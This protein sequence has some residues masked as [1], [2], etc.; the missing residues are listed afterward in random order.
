M[1]QQLSALE[2]YV[3]D[4]TTLVMESGESPFNVLISQPEVDAQ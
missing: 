3:S 2:G 4:K 1:L